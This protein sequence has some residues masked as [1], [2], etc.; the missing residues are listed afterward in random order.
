[1]VIDSQLELAFS[2]KSLR[3]VCENPAEAERA[4]GLRAAGSLRARLA[5]LEAARNIGE[6]LVGNPRP[7]STIANAF[8]IDLVEDLV[9]FF[10]SNHPSRN[11]PMNN[12]TDWDR[13][14]R[15]K[16]TKI[17]RSDV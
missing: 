4:Y 17:G 6:L 14:T 15:I 1:M 11:S 3:E 12:H 9:L 7:C 10:E 8:Q 2:T 16:L 13:V 5:D